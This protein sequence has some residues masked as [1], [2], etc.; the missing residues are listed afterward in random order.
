MKIIF[1]DYHFLIQKFG[2][3]SRYYYEIIKK[4]K[5]KKISV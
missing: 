3:V 1:Y 4:L 5:K 2:G